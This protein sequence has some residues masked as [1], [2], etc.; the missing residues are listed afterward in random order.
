MT[1]WVSMCVLDEK[2]FWMKSMCVLILG[3]GQHQLTFY[4]ATAMSVCL[5][6]LVM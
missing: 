3:A 2:V 1:K 5:H 4:G 6:W